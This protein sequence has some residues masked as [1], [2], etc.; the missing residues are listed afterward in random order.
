LLNKRAE[1]VLEIGK[2]K[3]E[4]SLEIYDPPFRD[5]EIEN[6]LIQINAGPLPN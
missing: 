6:K 5:K 2:L 3:K 1:V 4:N